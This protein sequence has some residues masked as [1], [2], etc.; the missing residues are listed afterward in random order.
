MADLKTNKQTI[1][2]PK[3]KTPPTAKAI[4]LSV[5]C[6]FSP[7]THTMTQT[8]INGRSHYKYFFTQN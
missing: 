5:C 7:P 6:L 1:T 3:T 2:N 8:P 4:V